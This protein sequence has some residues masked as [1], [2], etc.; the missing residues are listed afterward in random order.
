VGAESPGGNAS[1][2][3]AVPRRTAFWL[4]ASVWAVLLFG[5]AAPT[6]LYGVYQAEWRFSTTTLTAVFAI[7]A[8]VLLVTLLFLGSLSDYLG[9][10]PVIIA[11]LAIAAVACGLFLI[12]HGVALLFAARALQGLAVGLAMGTLGAALVELQPMRGELGALLTSAAPPTGLAVGALSASA[13]AQYAP[14][15][16]HLVW[17]L[18]LGAFVA[19]IL[20]VL[21]IPEP[22]PGRPGV[23]AS[24]RPRVGV[25][26]HARATFAVAVP[27]ML[28]VWALAGLYLSLGPS[29]AAQLAGS[30]NLLWGGLVVL[31]L[32][33]IG[34]AATALF[35]AANPPTA[36]LTGCFVLLTGTLI[37]F[38]AIITTTIAA[39]LLGT[40]VAGV[41]FGLAQ[42]GVFR[43]LVPLAAPAEQS[44]LIAAI[45]IVSYLAFS[46]PAVI[47]GIA[48]SHFGLHDTAIVYS[49]AIA[50]LVTATA[51]G[52][53][54]RTPITSGSH[55]PGPAP[56]DPPKDRCTP[57]AG[58]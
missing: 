46:I 20:A 29:L 17:W 37:T 36:M 34:A 47:A 3:G 39:F 14:A 43:T 58:R 13:L 38:V 51:G 27:S 49:L 35:R 18:L 33:G 24:L 6:P 4:L 32:L 22:A 45:F 55:E 11:S 16:T 23:L 40:A 26:R 42:L 41:G 2:P 8:L 57:A 52:L 21:A 1:R 12:A 56:D 44:G 48:T 28:A 53:L 9:R 30:Q 25:P 19:A 10:R 54:L 5:P 50:A 7:Y 15:P 31:L